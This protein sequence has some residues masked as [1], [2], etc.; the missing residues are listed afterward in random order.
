M[1]E[2]IGSVPLRRVSRYGGTDVRC[3]LLVDGLLVS[4]SDTS[5]SFSSKIPLSSEVSESVLKSMYVAYQKKNNTLVLYYYS[6][7]NKK[8]LLRMLRP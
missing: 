7:L 1:L 4:T 6:R 2:S 3:V 8:S 5:R